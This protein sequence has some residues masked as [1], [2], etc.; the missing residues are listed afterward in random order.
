MTEPLSTQSQYKAELLADLAD[1]W[2][3][4]E[5]L[6]DFGK[7]TILQVALSPELEFSPDEALTLAQALMEHGIHPDA[8]GITPEDRRHYHWP[9][10][11]GMA[12]TGHHGFN[13]D[14]LDLELVKLFLQHGADP[15]LAVKDVGE[16]R[17]VSSPLLLAA[18]RGNPAMCSALLEHGADPNRLQEARFYGS[19]PAQDKREELG[20]KGQINDYEG[21]LDGWG[22]SPLHL[23]AVRGHSA[24]CQLLLEHGADPLKTATVSVESSGSECSGGECVGAWTENPAQA[25]DR[26]GHP[27]TAGLIRS[28]VKQKALAAHLTNVEAENAQLRSERDQ[29]KNALAGVLGGSDPAPATP[30]RKHRL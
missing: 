24:V 13:R 26:S 6:D 3:P 9:T 10:P 23:A 11:L 22:V 27:E 25:A 21:W 2:D 15:N 14:D 19:F 7:R 17:R 30:E 8:S 20:F 16:T 5:V 18:R 12:I 1:G 29:L 28:F 4:T